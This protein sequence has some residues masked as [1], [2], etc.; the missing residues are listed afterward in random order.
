MSLPGLHLV[1][2]VVADLLKTRGSRGGPVL[3][4]TVE[5]VRLASK[6]SPD[7]QSY[8]GREEES[9]RACFNRA[10]SA[11][12]ADEYTF[13]IPKSVSRNAMQH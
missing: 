6:Q 3:G 8:H 12:W 7:V 11:A 1:H 13:P 9:L 2:D 5:D 10:R 4:E